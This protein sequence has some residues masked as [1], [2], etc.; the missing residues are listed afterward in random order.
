[1]EIFP[2]PQNGFLC[3]NSFE[4]RLQFVS[5]SVCEN[6]EDSEVQEVLFSYSSPCTFKVIGMSVLDNAQL[7]PLLL[8][9]P[10]NLYFCTKK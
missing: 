9:S 1:M 6:R 4:T 10:Y 5:Q 3:F 2:P 7:L 8:Q